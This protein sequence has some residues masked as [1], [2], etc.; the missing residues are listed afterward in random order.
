MRIKWEWTALML[1]PLSAAGHHS[2]A[3]NFDQGAVIEIEGRLTEVLW[4]NPHV[5]FEVAVEPPGGGAESWSVELTSLSNLRRLGISPD[6]VKVG[7]EVKIAGN[8][9]R[10]GEHSLYAE[11]VLRP[12]GREVLLEANV[13]PRWS[14][15]TLSASATALAT[16]GDGSRPDLGFFRVWSTPMRAP[17]LFPENVA[18]NFDFSRYPL[19]AAARAAVEAFDPIT[20]S[21]TLNCAPKGMPTMMEQPYPMEIVRD[22]EKF[23][24]RLE[25]YDTVRTVYLDENDA[26][27]DAQPSRLGVSI[28]RLDGN[29]LTVTTRDST[30]PYF[31]VVGIPQS[32]AA[33]DVE[34]FSLSED[35]SRLDYSITVTDPV[36]FT[37]PVTLRKYWIWI[38]GVTVK[39]YNCTETN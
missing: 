25:E 5:H 36:N 15:E 10:R 26:P 9:S 24:V 29:T 31:D 20:D 38:P 2:V 32:P 14:S 23:L 13:A 39:Q 33:V 19:T 28:G 4:R 8:P 1:L 7:D 12:D 37:E 6:F 21:P 17:M 22:G 35:G 27:T 30:W 34:Q 11:N 18:S 3:A 16:E